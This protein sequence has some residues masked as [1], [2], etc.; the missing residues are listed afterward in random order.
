MMI[1]MMVPLVVLPYGTALICG[2][3]MYWAGATVSGCA[4]SVGSRSVF[5]SSINAWSFLCRV[6]MISGNAIVLNFLILR[7]LQS[8]ANVARFG[9]CL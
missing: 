1:L 4:A 9:R 3:L 8:M 5:I 2:A 6:E 7:N